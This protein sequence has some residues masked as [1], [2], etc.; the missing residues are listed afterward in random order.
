MGA[1]IILKKMPYFIEVQKDKN[2]ESVKVRRK[3]KGYVEIAMLNELSMDKTERL[4]L[5][6]DY[7]KMKSALC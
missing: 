3:K 5:K 4:R 1:V 6:K 7:D 2:G